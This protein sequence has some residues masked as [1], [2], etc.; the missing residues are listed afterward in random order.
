MAV[1]VAT[2]FKLG[3][4]R[5]LPRFFAGTMA[6]ARQARRSPGFV[7]GR[8]RVEPGGV[9][10]TLT[11]WQSGRDMVAFRNAGAHAAVVPRLGGWACEA[12]FGVW[13]VDD[14]GVP[15]W[16]EASRRLAEHPN[17][18]TLD[19]PSAAHLAGTFR[20]ARQL[21]LDMPLFRRRRR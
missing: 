8:L 21:G 6:T 5:H 16:A 14:E 11:T 17:F 7:G 1:V 18:A 13:N 12:V 2:R 15:S 10:W 9:Y 3:S 19:E 4:A 20:P